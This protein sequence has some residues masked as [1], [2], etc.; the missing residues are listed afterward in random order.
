MTSGSGGSTVGSGRRRIRL[1][2]VGPGDPD[3]VTLEAVRAMREVDF[4]V[5]SDKSPR[6]G[7]PDPL[8]HARE[9]MLDR[10]L[11]APAVVVRVEDPERERRVDRTASAADYE[12]VVAAAGQPLGSGV[13]VAPVSAGARRR[14]LRD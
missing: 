3:Q 6:G 14:G 2:G 5:V 7:M 8:V 9:R 4:F 1:I 11:D 13:M 12:A 10:H